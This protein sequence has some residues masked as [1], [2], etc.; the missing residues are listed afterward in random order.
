M[1]QADRDAILVVGPSWVGDMVM[2]QSL[3]KVLKAARPHAAIDVLA[4]A[5]SLPIVARMPEVRQ[6]IASGTAHGKLGLQDRRA[7]ASEL[8][9]RNYA[10]AIVLPRSLKAA[11]IPWLADIPRRTGYRGE[12]RYFLINDVRPFDATLLDQTVKRF[13]F[14][15]VEGAQLPANI[16]FPKLELSK[17][18]QAAT[19]ARLGLQTDRPVV[20]MMPGAEYGPAKCWPLEYFAALAAQLNASGF[21]VWVMGSDKDAAAGDEIAAGSAAVNICGK[22]ELED[23]VD[24]LG[25]AGQAV[26]NDSGLMHI[27]AAVGCHV[28]AIYGSSSPRFTPPLTD[29]CSVHYLE[30]DCSPCFKRECPLGHLDCLRKLEVAEVFAEITAKRG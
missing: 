23:V 29:S 19:L 12:S 6:G 2:A 14:L 20:A 27:A 16:P 15:G 7:V 17:Q 13:V 1:P 26:S 10:Q 3:F 30:L 22:T 25:F 28:Q 24:L 5:W 21:D 4:P 9:G 8:R 18:R 11:L